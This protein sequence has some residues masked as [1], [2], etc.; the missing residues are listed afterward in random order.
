MAERLWQTDSINQAA[1]KRERRCECGNVTQSLTG[2]FVMGAVHMIMESIKS[3][4]C[5]TFYRQIRRMHPPIKEKPSFA[6]K[7]KIFCCSK[8]SIWLVQRWKWYGNVFT[9][10]SLLPATWTSKLQAITVITV[11][12]LFEWYFT[13][14]LQ[15]WLQHKQ[16]FTLTLTTTN[17]TLEYAFQFTTDIRFNKTWSEE[18]CNRL[19]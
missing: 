7:K 8:N 3:L 6:K 12:P 19:F 13:T 14:V 1:A 2:F 9:G 4:W 17:T 16:V 5:W 11:I 18:K 10:I 15:W